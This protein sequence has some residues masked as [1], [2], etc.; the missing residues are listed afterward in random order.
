MEKAVGVIVFTILLGM[1]LYALPLFVSPPSYVLRSS[2][3][4]AVST[5]GGLNFS[6]A[7]VHT[8]KNPDIT[9]LVAASDGLMFAGSTS[10]LLVSKDSGKNWYEWSDLEKN[11]DSRTV[12]Y[13]IAK[14]PSR[15][16]EIY[17]ATFGDKG[18]A[19]YRTNDNFF[20][21]LK[22]WDDK[23]IAPYALTATGSELY[24][25]LS[26]GRVLSYNFSTGM[27]KG[28]AALGSPVTN[29]KARG[30]GAIIYAAT[31]SGGIFA[32]FDGGRSFEELRGDISAYPGAMRITRM[33]PDA[34]TLNRVYAASFS[35]LFRSD[36]Y[37]NSW[38]AVSNIVPPSY[39]ISVLEVQNNG[40]LFVGA[41][42][43]LYI[44]DDRGENWR[45]VTPFASSRRLSAINI[46][47][48]KTVVVGTAAR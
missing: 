6:A 32:S 14:N 24:F 9:V 42:E 4:L 21:L 13:D 46:L 8:S 41:G 19:I 22:I 44:S 35:S 37:G 12:V 38:V 30:N 23:K 28:L 39:P 45:I 43:K 47:S 33:A 25:G 34:H 29:L 7:D 31:K 17:I 48:D 36:D 10:G 3:I 5:D 11:I 16:S 2:Q 40:R 1:A 18:G 20:T 26:D 27:L 15:A